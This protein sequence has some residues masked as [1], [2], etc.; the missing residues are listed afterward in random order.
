MHALSFCPGFQPAS[1][2]QSDARPTGDQEV[3]GLILAGFG[4][5]FYGDW[6]WN[7][8]LFS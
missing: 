8:F 2:V 5:F 3:A 4:T 6:S 1:L 7:I